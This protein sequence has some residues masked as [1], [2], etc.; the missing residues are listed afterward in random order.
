MAGRTGQKG[1]LGGCVRGREGC[2]CQVVMRVHLGLRKRSKAGTAGGRAEG[3]WWCST[4]L[5][6]TQGCSK[7]CSNQQHV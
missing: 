3:R 1:C 5:D 2:A 7:E 4:T 6:H